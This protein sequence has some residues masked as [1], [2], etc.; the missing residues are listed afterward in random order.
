[1]NI[2]PISYKEVYL[3]A[4]AHN[5]FIF[6]LNLRLASPKMVLVSHRYKF[7]YL[8]NKK[9]AGT[10]VEMYYERFCLSPDE[11]SQH[12]PQHFA[13]ERISAHGIISARI[14]RIGQANKLGFYNHMKYSELV[15]L[16]GSDSIQD[17]IVFCV[18][19]NPYDVMVS[20]YFYSMAKLLTFESE[21]EKKIFTFEKYLRTGKFPRNTSIYAEL[22][23][24]TC[25]FF[26]RFESLKEDMLALN[27]LLSLPETY[28]INF[29]SY[30]PK[31]KADIRPKTG[32]EEED[33]HAYRQYYNDECKRLVED[34]F[35]DEIAYFGYTF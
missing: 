17:Y 27:K 24:E 31:E 20:H 1:L 19:R 28:S 29:D 14:E 18:V 26:I 10:S 30:L 4:E 22:G 35:K 32:D 16:V 9:V 33:K 13:D 12:I 25:S 7:V 2:S 23:F 34:L 5:S 21:E 8:R 6:Q 3:Q 15:K 11:E